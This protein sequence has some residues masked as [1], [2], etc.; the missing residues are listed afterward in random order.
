LGTFRSVPSSLPE[1]LRSKQHNQDKV[2]N[3]AQSGFLLYS[4]SFPI[5][6]CRSTGLWE[7]NNKPLHTGHRVLK[8]YTLYFVPHSLYPFLLYPRKLEVFQG[9]CVCVC[10]CLCVCVCVCAP[11]C[12]PVCACRCMCTCVYACVHVHVCACRYMCTCVHTCV[13]MHADVCAHV[14]MHVCMYMCVHAG[15]CAHMYMHAEARS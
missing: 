13:C 8:R 9:Y 11:A 2:W 5:N 3:Q 14:Y 1:D 4:L 15:A 10:V 12:V 7:L 6:K